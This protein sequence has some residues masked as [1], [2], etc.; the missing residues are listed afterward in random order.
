MATKEKKKV[1][2]DL[3]VKFNEAKS[4]VLT[5]YRGLNVEQMTELRAK[6]R[7]AGVD[8]KVAKNTLA[9]LAAKEAGCEDIKDYL[10]G[11]TAIAFSDE[12]PV[13]PA[14]I[15]SEFAEEHEALE[16]KSGLLDKDVLDIDE[17]ES[18]ANVPSREELLGRL[19]SGLKRPLNGLVHCLKDPVKSLAYA[20][21]AVKDKKE[22][23]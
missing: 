5:D 21:K 3:T 18:L 6:L 17:V 16:I 7:E 13:A 9:Y 4:A 22:E 23:N 1:I 20:L 2:D 19:A 14:K 15:L 10:K 11:P 12:D 8:Y